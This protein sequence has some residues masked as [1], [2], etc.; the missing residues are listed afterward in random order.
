MPHL[1]C[2]PSGWTVLS[3]CVTAAFSLNCG[4]CLGITALGGE[5]QPASWSRFLPLGEE[6]PRAERESRRACGLF[7]KD[8]I[9][10]LGRIDPGT[11][12]QW[13]Q[14]TPTNL[15]SEDVGYARAQEPHVTISPSFGP[16]PEGRYTMVPSTRLWVEDQLI[17][18][19]ASYIEAA[20][21]TASATVSGVELTSAITS[22]TWMEE[23]KWYVLVVTSSTRSLNLETTSVVLR[24][25][26][27]AS[28]KGSAFWNPH[29]A[30]VLSRP[31]QTRGAISNQDSTVKELD[32]EWASPLMN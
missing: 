21:Q 15:R 9:Q 10:G 5:T 32:A 31:V 2:V 14:T 12:S 28:S 20:T 11:T 13:P 1:E 29:M 22:A 4:L 25:T 19:D 24:D 30:G 6:C 18:Q 3:G 7:Q 8:V 16:I 17:G 23:E 26:V 27:T